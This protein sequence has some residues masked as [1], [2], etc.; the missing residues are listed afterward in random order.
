M[1]QDGEADADGDAV[2]RGEQGFVE[3]PD[4]VEEVR[5][6]VRGAVLL[7]GTQAAHLAEVLTGRERAARGR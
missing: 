5:E 2:H 7:A 6:T 4:R 1:Q 3:R